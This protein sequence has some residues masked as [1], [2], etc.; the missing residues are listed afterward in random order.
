MWLNAMLS[1]TSFLMASNNSKL[2]LACA[3][4]FNLLMLTTRPFSV[5][6]AFHVL[7]CAD[8]PS[9]HIASYPAAELGHSE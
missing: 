5:H 7:P 6:E 3:S 1:D 8:L 4:K 2:R 9:S